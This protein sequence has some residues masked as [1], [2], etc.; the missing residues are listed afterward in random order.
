MRW[1]GNDDV[2]ITLAKLNAQ[3]TVHLK[4]LYG[5]VNLLRRSTAG[6][7]IAVLRG[8]PSYSTVGGHYWRFDESR[9]P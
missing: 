4:T 6:P 8:D 7:I 5:G 1:S 3:S 2:M 9:A